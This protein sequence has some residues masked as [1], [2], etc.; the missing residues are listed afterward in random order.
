[1]ADQGLV[2]QKKLYKGG[3]INRAVSGLFLIKPGGEKEDNYLT[4]PK[5]SLAV[6]ATKFGQG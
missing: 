4:G 5:L 2:P 1:M 3:G 6:G